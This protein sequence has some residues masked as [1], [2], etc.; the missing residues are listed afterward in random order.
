M[1]PSEKNPAER[2]ARYPCLGAGLVGLE[3]DTVGDHWLVLLGDGGR[4]VGP[5]WRQAWSPAGRRRSVGIRSIVADGF[6]E[7]RPQ[8]RALPRMRWE[9]LLRG[10]LSGARTPNSSCVLLRR[11]GSAAGMNTLTR[12]HPLRE[13]GDRITRPLRANRWLWLADLTIICR[14]LNS[15]FRIGRAQLRTAGRAPHLI[16]IILSAPRKFMR[17]GARVDPAIRAFRV[18]LGI[19]AGRYRPPSRASPVWRRPPSPA[20]R[21][22]SC[23]AHRPRRLW[24]DCRQKG[25]DFGT[26]LSFTAEDSKVR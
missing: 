18:V 20:A 11:Q 14:G 19:A 12:P 26:L 4:G 17:S 16:P 1:S 9:Y 23:A 25:T 10:M 15:F 3:A 5:R 7:A 2:F 24:Q 8:G 6:S 21:S 22:V 13:C